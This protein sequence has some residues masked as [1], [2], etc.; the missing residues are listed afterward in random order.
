MS[1][2][3]APRVVCVAGPSGSGKTTLI[4]RL[5]AH[6]AVPRRRIGIVKHTHH[7]IRWHPRGKD[8]GELWAEGPGALAVAGPDQTAVFV[9]ADAEEGGAGRDAGGDRAAPGG[10]G[11]AGDDAT[12]A[13]GAAGDSSRSAAGGARTS[14]ATRALV[15]A[16][17]RL[18][19]GLELVLVEGFT[20]AEAPT[21]WVA[22]ELRPDLAVP[23]LR[24]VAVPSRRLA[25]WGEAA[26]PVPV[27]ARED[28]EELARRLA[29][30]AVPVT[31]LPAG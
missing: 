13:A 10:A 19:G 22:R 9:P 28:P 15:R 1:D 8:S 7:R 26:P 25:A 4:R 20:D 5:L 21:L 17:R 29:G 2:E 24:G 14:E 6:L 16:C 12:P 30:W 3:R 11:A 18:P 27:F 23:G 31:K